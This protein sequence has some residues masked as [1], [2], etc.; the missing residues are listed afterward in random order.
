[1]QESTSDL[2]RQKI[3]I[4]MSPIPF[5]LPDGFVKSKEENSQSI[6]QLSAEFEEQQAT[7]KTPEV[8]SKKLESCYLLITESC[9]L[10]LP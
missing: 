10:L 7:C 1:M 4:C 3:L 2:L 9:Y 8:Y 5:G 6:T